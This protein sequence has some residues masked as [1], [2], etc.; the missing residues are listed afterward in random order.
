MTFLGAVFMMTSSKK[1]VD[2]GLWRAATHGLLKAPP[3][4]S[5]FF[6]RLGV[7]N[8]ITAKRFYLAFQL[9]S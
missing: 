7:E 2:S 4:E 5:T 9:K 8:A 6:R 1:K 3:P